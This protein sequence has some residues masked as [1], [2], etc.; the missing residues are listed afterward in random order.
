[1]FFFHY[2]SYSKFFP[3]SKAHKETEKEGVNSSYT[4]W[5]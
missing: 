1:M 5:E 2:S 3:Y 4:L